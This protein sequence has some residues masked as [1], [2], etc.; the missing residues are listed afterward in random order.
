MTAYRT[1]CMTLVLAA[2]GGDAFTVVAGDAGD[3]D[4]FSL[5]PDATGVDDQPADVVDGAPT[6]HDGGLAVDDVVAPPVDAYVA[7]AGT[8]TDAV[9]VPMEAAPLCAVISCPACSGTLETPCCASSTRCGCSV[10]GVTGIC[11]VV[12]PAC[13]ASSCPSCGLQGTGCCTDAGTCGCTGFENV[14]GCT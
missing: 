11:M 2:C 10:Y 4:A 13:V 12:A 9:S 7:D 3:Q 1:A 14:G 5:S 8:E 6:V